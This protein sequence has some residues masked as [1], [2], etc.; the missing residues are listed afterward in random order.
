MDHWR[1]VLSSGRLLEVDFEGLVENGEE[2][3]RRMI[4]FA[5]LQPES[6]ERSVNT[7]WRVRQPIYK[8]LVAR[9]RRFE[10]SLG[11]FRDLLP[12]SPGAVR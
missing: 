3:T 6:N 10:P 8:T 11:E 12:E 4:Q 9:W 7:V 5:C 1:T 2:A